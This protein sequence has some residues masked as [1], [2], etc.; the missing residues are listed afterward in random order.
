MWSAVMKTWWFALLISAAPQ[1]GSSPCWA[2]NSAA[3]LAKT[4]PSIETMRKVMKS[5]AE[6]TA[7]GCAG[8][9]SQGTGF[10]FG[11]SNSI[12][13]ALHV[14][15][16]CKTFQILF[17]TELGAKSHPAKVTHVLQSRDLALLE[18][19]NPGAKTEP[20]RA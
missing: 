19:E 17:E 13:T 2:Q 16:G 1:F 3:L 8:K 20:L 4:G 18:L 12:V 5:V 15:A 9:D 10:A 6:V 14:V 7:L 11:G